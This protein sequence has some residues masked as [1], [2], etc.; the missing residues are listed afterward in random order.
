MTEAHN[1]PLYRSKAAAD[2]AVIWAAKL[3]VV[4]RVTRV[5]YGITTRTDYDPSNPEHQGR[6][7]FMFPEGPKIGWHWS[8]LVA[9][10]DEFVGTPIGTVGRANPSHPRKCF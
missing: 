7:A 2:G 5:A 6:K 10:V 1:D 4:G 3:V 9:K 8:E